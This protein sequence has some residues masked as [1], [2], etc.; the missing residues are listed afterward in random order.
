MS[1]PV[2]SITIDVDLR[3]PGQFFACCG[4]LE[5]AGRLWPGS[6]GWFAS[7]DGGAVFHVATGL[8]T[9]DAP[10]VEIVRALCEPEQL[11]CPVDD[12]GIEDMQADRRPVL[13][14]GF[15]LRLDWWLDSYRGGDKSEL[16]VWAGQQTPER[17][18]TALRDIWRKIN[19]ERPDEIGTRRLF[20]QRWPET[21]MGFD[22]SSSWKSID[23]GFSPDEQQINVLTS[24]AVEILAAIGLQRCRP[25]LDHH[26]KGRWFIYRAWAD[27]L[28]IAVAPAG[29]VGSVRA[30]S[31]H[32]FQVQMRNSQYGN[33]GW[34]KPL[35]EKS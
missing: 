16:K 21:G 24:P 2:P 32:V 7:E 19:A 25:E 28:E 1:R 13:L 5:L 23:I 27:P 15:A 6:E 29:V 30:K 33:F 14:C 35:E 9:K 18:L 3:N 10:L 22:P 8:G 11:L 34:A 12:D 17:N 31:A 20:S 26:R 4:I